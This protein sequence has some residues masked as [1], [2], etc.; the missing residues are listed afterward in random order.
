MCLLIRGRTCKTDKHDE[1]HEKFTYLK[2]KL[3]S[4]RYDSTQYLYKRRL[5]EKLTAKEEFGFSEIYGNLIKSLY[6]TAKETLGKSTKDK[7]VI[8]GGQK[9]LKVL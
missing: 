7:A 2:Y 3:D 4:F 1:N 8:C 6:E 5:D 9:K